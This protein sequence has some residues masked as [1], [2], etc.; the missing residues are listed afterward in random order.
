MSRGLRSAW[1]WRFDRR[2]PERF[3]EVDGRCGWPERGARCRNARVRVRGDAR[4]AAQPRAVGTLAPAEAATRGQL[5]P[6]GRN[7]QHSS[8]VRTKVECCQAT[9][10]IRVTHP[11]RRLHARPAERAVRTCPCAPAVAWSARAPASAG[12]QSP[13]AFQSCQ[14]FPGLVRIVDNT[15]M[16]TQLPGPSLF[17]A[18]SGRVIHSSV[19]AIPPHRPYPHHPPPHPVRRPH[20]V[21]CARH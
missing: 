12:L 8:T 5:P 21:P 15:T 13:K 18:A 11:R 14:D 16:S 6:V 2:R 3:T 19:A 7:V 20:Y 4:S 10:A 17:V 9:A 1:A